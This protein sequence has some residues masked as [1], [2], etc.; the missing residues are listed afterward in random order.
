MCHNVT[1]GTEVEI[2]CMVQMSGTDVVVCMQHGNWAHYYANKSKKS[3]EAFYLTN[4]SGSHFDPVFV[5]V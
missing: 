1:W 2:I 4:S 5:Y 3:N